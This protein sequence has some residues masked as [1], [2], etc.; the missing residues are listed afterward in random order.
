MK[1]TIPVSRHDVSRLP[2]FIDTLIHFGGLN[3]HSAFFFATPA[4]IVEV[5]EQSARLKPHMR[6]VTVAQALYEPEFGMPMDGGILFFG[7]VFNLGRSQ[8]REPFLW[9]ELD[10]LP[11]KPDW[12]N[13]IQHDY[14]AKGRLCYGNIVPL[15][16]IVNGKLEYR[17]GE[18]YMM[19]VG[20]YPPTMHTD[21]A[22]RPLIQDLGMPPHSNPKENF[23]TY[24]RGGVKTLGWANSNLIADMWNTGCYEATPEGIK[25]FARPT[26]KLVRCRGGLVPATAVLVHGCKD[27]S[28]RQI[29]MGEVKPDM[30]GKKLP[31]KMVLIQCPEGAGKI[32]MSGLLK[33]VSP[34]PVEELKTPEPEP[35]APTPAQTPEPEPPV[36]QTLPPKPQPPQEKPFLVDMIERKLRVGSYRMNEL[37]KDIGVRGPNQL[38]RLKEEVLGFG[39]KV[40]TP[41]WISRGD[42]VGEP[43]PETVEVPANAAESAANADDVDI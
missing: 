22:I 31:Q 16:F 32:D 27:D 9:L 3:D 23:D 18:E 36:V 11:I 4:T 37:A 14:F 35:E 2:S 17:A 34:V 26:D 39:F 5:T 40:S 13:L 29:V 8:N 38:A 43:E 21:E 10:S 15:P 6:E 28:L 12:L 30:D 41:G 24:I 42:S 19:A 25:C 7:A 33:Q 20:V 1:L